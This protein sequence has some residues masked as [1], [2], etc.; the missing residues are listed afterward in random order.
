MGD[1]WEGFAGWWSWGWKGWPAL[2]AIGTV[3]AFVAA[4]WLLAKE[5]RAHSSEHLRLRRDQA[6]KIAA[7]LGEYGRI[8]GEHRWTVFLRNA[9]DSPVFWLDLLIV[10]PW[11][12]EASPLTPK[13]ACWAT[14]PPGETQRYTYC[15]EPTG[16]DAQGDRSHSGPG[17]DIHFVDSAGVAWRRFTNGALQECQGG[18]GRQHIQ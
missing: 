7:W 14:H 15:M 18:C 17:A 2:E 5:M 11:P 3:G 9:S 12:G 1:L 8:G 6:S 13:D 4:A 10:D 16:P